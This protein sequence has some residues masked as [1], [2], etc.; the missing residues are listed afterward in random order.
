MPTPS[1][2]G[3]A[4][5]ISCSSPTV[6]RTCRCSSAPTSRIAPVSACSTSTIRSSNAFER[7]LSERCSSAASETRPS[8]RSVA[9]AASAVARACRSR[10]RS[11]V[12][13]SSARLRRTNWPSCAPIAVRVRS[14]SGSRGRRAVLEGLEHP[15][16]LALDQHR[17]RDSGA[18]PLGRRDRG[19]SEPR[20]LELLEPLRRARGRHATGEHLGREGQA[21]R[22]REKTVELQARSHP[23]GPGLVGLDRPEECN[24][25]A[26][27]L[28]DRSQQARHRFP[29]GLRTAEH[30]RDRVLQLGP[31]LGSTPVRDL[32]DDRSD[33]DRLAVRSD[34]GVVA[35]R[36]SDARR[37]ARPGVPEACSSPITG[38]RR[39][40][41][42]RAT[43]SITWAIWG[44]TSANVLPDMMPPA[45]A[46]LIAREGVVDPDVAELAVPEAEADR[47]AP[48]E[49][50]EERGRSLRLFVERLLL[51][52]Q[53]P[54]ACSS[55]RERTRSRA[56]IEP[57]LV[58]HRDRRHLRG[59]Q[60]WPVGQPPE[61]HQ[62]RRGLLACRSPAARQQRSDR[63]ARPCS[64]QS[65][66]RSR[67]SSAGRREQLL[68]RGVAGQE[69][70][71]L[72]RIH[73]PARRRP[74]TITPSRRWRRTVSKQLARAPRAR[75][76]TAPGLAPRTRSAY[77]AGSKTGRESSRQRSRITRDA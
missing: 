69:G 9:A 70:R 30:A 72:V 19:A 22:H 75:T 44:T 36:A 51:F 31:L 42:R 39:S 52:D 37:R 54:L 73:A 49:G 63:A 38:S 11:C 55:P 7:S 2:T 61:P 60:R 34:D 13:S 65:S 15:D 57:S 62:H 53:A 24:V 8:F 3:I 47:R 6:A 64:S 28:D 17:E 46:S 20:R 29:D 5:T 40:S 43:G 67:G 4:R 1:G 16:H 76:Q 21:L 18:K 50:V 66:N 48:V 58:A 68:D 10:C 77:I 26:E 32:L 23:D 35:R 45:R 59:L 12:R 33:A 41:T 25:P 74:T 14:S 56:A 71:L 27:G